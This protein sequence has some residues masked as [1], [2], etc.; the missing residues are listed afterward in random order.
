MSEENQ[1][2]ESNATDGGLPGGQE[3]Q[4]GAEGGA[5][6]LTYEELQ[7]ELAKTR[8][9]AAG[10]RVKNNELET[11][12]SDFRKWKESQMTE[13][14]KAQ[15][16]LQEVDAERRQDYLEIAQTKF[17]LE[18]DDL[19][20]LKGTTKAEILASAE[21]YSSRVGSKASEKDEELQ[22]RGNPN[23]FPGTR[24]TP[25]GSGASDVNARLR[26]QLLGR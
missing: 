7:A 22:Q 9:E 24:G 19:E 15:A 20:F 13:L 2:Q 8:R 17:G 1:D 5:P 25:V 14:E 6:K 10:K 4:D 3:A 16:R 23:L 12:L 11:E 21:K 26:E 18:D